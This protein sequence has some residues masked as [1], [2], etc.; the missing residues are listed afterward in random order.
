MQ[1]KI[2]MTSLLPKEDGLGTKYTKEFEH[3]RFL[4]RHL[5]RECLK[6]RNVEFVL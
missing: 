4:D 6:E 1:G 2:A 5:E 3:A